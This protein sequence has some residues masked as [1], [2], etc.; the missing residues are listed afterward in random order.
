MYSAWNTEKR[1]FVVRNH[2]SAGFLCVWG[3]SLCIGFALP[4][5]GTLAHPVPYAEDFEVP[6][7]SGTPANQIGAW[8]SGPLDVSTVVTAVVSFAASTRPIP[9]SA[10][11]QVLHLE[12]RS[13]G[14]TN[15]LELLDSN[16]VIYLD[17]LLNLS[18]RSSI[19]ASAT[20]DPSVQLFF[21]LNA[22][23]HLVVYNGGVDGTNRTMTMMS[24]PE[25]TPGEWNRFTVTM[26][27]VNG[28]SGPVDRKYFKIQLNGTSLTSAQAY[29]AP[30]QTGAFDGG[31]WF[32]TADQTGP[33]SIETLAFEGIGALDE[34]VVTTRA[35]LFI[36]TQV[37]YV[38][39]D[40]R[41]QGA[42]TPAKEVPVIAGSAAQVVY[43]ADPWHEILNLH[44]NGV[45]I[46]GAAGAQVY[47]AVVSNV[48]GDITHQVQFVESV[49]IADGKTP[50]GWY[51]PLGAD[52]SQIDEDGDGLTLNEEYWL[53]SNPA[54]SNSFTFARVRHGDENRMPVVGWASEGLPYGRIVPEMSTNLV[55]GGWVELGGVLAQEGFMTTWQAPGELP[56][57]T[58]F[59][60]LKAME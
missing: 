21:Y 33:D 7:T 60:R 15:Q 44:R 23:S 20:N 4:A 43:Q 17:A 56:D 45:E 25:L 55:R 11:E 57:S 42:M 13:G 38:T 14:L 18:A 58:F 2:F 54:I 52:G 3:L 6:L 47:T 59:L 34:L 24:A 29:S 27:F 19:P 39:S 46:P 8:Q 5:D 12:T 53:N 36:T 22:D 37:F 30:G 48:Q 31:A 16:Q 51:G 50:A 49:A 40:L 9:S 32:F 10:D 35:P 41:G 1:P 28:D 26:D